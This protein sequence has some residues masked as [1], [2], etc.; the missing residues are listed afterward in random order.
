MA[1]KR[2]WRDTASRPKPAKS[3]QVARSPAMKSQLKAKAKVSSGRG[4][5][6]L[7]KPQ[8]RLHAVLDAIRVT[9]DD[10]ELRLVYADALEES[11]E[12]ERA[13][14]IRAHVTKAERAAALQVERDKVLATQLV[15]WRSDRG[16]VWHVEARIEEWLAHGP[17]LF[18]TEPI[19]SIVVRDPRNEIVDEDFDYVDLVAQL[20]KQS[21]LGYV[22]A[23]EVPPYSTL[24]EPDVVVELL[25]SPHLR[26]M[27]RLQV[28]H[29]LAAIAAAK[30]CPMPALREL[31]IHCEGS[32]EGDDALR[33]FANRRDALAR[34]ELVGC[35]MSA[36]GIRT[37]VD[38]GWRLEHLITAG[39]HYQLDDIGLAG[40]ASIARAPALASLGELRIE[41]AGLDD[42]A[43]QALAESP[44][45]RSLHTLGLGGNQGITDAGIAA[46]AKSPVLASV[47]EIDLTATAVTEHGVGALPRHL[48]V[49]APHLR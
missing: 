25:G 29:P 45:L 40:L 36:D 31:F 4:A 41:S 2:T 48:Q 22:H 24:G 11:G 23:L 10:D 14:L 43:M 35:G 30:H 3:R 47:R 15:R 39:T 49:I 9:P 33:A 38:A 16:L 42:G 21:W 18:E 44:H 34:L 1:A 12:L 5:A 6:K 32:T 20:A 46:L 7:A 37:M 8:D 13:E 17:Q 28:G 27:A 26:R 19:T